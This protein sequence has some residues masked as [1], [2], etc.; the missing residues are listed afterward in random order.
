MFV[1]VNCVNISVDVAQIDIMDYKTK[2][3]FIGYLDNSK[4][5][6]EVKLIINSLINCKCKDLFFCFEYLNSD[7]VLLTII[8]ANSNYD[9]PW[10][11]NF[12]QKKEILT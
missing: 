9:D 3:E 8:D 6:Q 1:I 10:K 5:S 2:R 11:L 4:K 12:Y 7:E